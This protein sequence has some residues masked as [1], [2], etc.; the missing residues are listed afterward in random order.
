[1]Y[2]CTCIVIQLCNVMQQM[3]AFQIDE[4]IQFSASFTDFEYHVFIIKK[5]ICTCSFIWYIFHAEIIIKV[6]EI[7]I[8]CQ[9]ISISIKV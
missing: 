8:K 7:S 6:Y 5:T 3:H 1:M 2:F 9:V 4:L